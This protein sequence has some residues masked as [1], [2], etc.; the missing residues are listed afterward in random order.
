M[1][2]QILEESLKQLEDYY[3]S[4]SNTDIAISQVVYGISAVGVLIS[5]YGLGTCFS[6]AG[7]DLIRHSKVW[8]NAGNLTDYCAWD[9]A[10]WALEENLFDRAV[11]IATLNALAY[12]YATEKKFNLREKVFLPDVLNV[13]RGEKVGLVGYMEPVIHRFQS[14]GAKVVVVDKDPHIL[15]KAKQKQLRVPV[16][17]DSKALKGAD[18]IVTTA[19]CLVYHSFKDIIEDSGNCNSIALI[20]PTAGLPPDVLFRHG[21]VVI[22]R[23][24]ITDIERATRVIMEGGLPGSKNGSAKKAWIL[25]TDNKEF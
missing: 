16:F 17:P 20:G 23:Q 15:A 25:F 13:K 2:S 22:G 1:A 6:A 12:R 14:A 10:R 18:H 21:V 11:G 8:E 7:E 24:I 5:G 4:R 3:S 9:L 19:A